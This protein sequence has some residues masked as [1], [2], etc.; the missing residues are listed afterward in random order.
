[1][2]VTGYLWAFL[3]FMEQMTE[4][5]NTIYI[6]HGSDHFI[7]EQFIPVRNGDWMP[8]PA[9]GTGLWGSRDTQSE[10]YFGW[11]EWCREN[12]FNLDRLSHSFRFILPDSH[13]LVLSS[14]EDLIPLPKL[15]PWEPK[16]IGW[17][18]DLKPGEIPTSEQLHEF[19][20]P[21]WCYL[22]F[23][24]LAEE[25]DAIELRNSGLF[26]DSLST[27]DCDCILVLNGEKIK[28]IT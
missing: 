1:M 23:E 9:H 5:D 21:N 4:S 16:E 26:R 18:E 13:I 27:W 14:E 8:K 20:A 7:P 24:K 11:E 2:T 10:D 15:N 19:Y 25:Y 6:H 17:M 28:E 12:H 22:D 3:I